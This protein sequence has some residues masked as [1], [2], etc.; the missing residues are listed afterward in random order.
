MGKLLAVFFLLSLNIFSQSEFKPE[1][2]IKVLMVIDDSGIKK[3]EIFKVTA[4]WKISYN[5]KI[6]DAVFSVYLHK[7]DG[8]FV[9]VIVS[10][11]EYGRGEAFC[12]YTGEFYLSIAGMDK[13]MV[14][15]YEIE[16]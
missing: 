16:Y 11:D 14:I 6:E 9:D 12:N 13:W 5:N 7:P 1:D 10:T 3:S 4:P 2:K 8:E 15:V